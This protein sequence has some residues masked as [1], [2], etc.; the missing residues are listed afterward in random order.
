MHTQASDDAVS[1]LQELELEPIL[2]SIVDS[3]YKQLQ[4]EKA[5]RK[6]AASTCSGR[7]TAAAAADSSSRRT[8]TERAVTVRADGCSHTGDANTLMR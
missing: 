5:T 4:V 7:T 6:A 3:G 8:L 1:L 2:E